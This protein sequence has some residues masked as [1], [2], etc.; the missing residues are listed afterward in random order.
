MPDFERLAVVRARFGLAGLLVAGFVSDFAEDVSELVPGDDCPP[1]SGSVDSGAADSVGS[2]GSVGSAGGDSG[3]TAAFDGPPD[4]VTFGMVSSLSSGHG[5]T[6]DTAA[7]HNPHRTTGSCTRFTPTGVNRTDCTRPAARHPSV[8]HAT[9]TI[10]ST[11]APSRCRPDLQF[12]H[13]CSPSANRVVQ[14]AQVG[15]TKPPAAERR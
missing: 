12:G 1:P 11:A 6:V 4:F 13:C 14:S 8:R 9:S 3:A 5:V 10:G 2:V 7:P 15:I